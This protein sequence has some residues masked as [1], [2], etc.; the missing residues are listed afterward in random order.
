MILSNFLIGIEY[1]RR[2]ISV[3]F[4]TLVLNELVMIAVE[5]NT[6]HKYMIFAE[7]ASFASYFLS[8]PFLEEYFGM[9]SD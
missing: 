7:M 8:I 4:T 3:S 5:I 1:Q 9:S 2:L 6:W